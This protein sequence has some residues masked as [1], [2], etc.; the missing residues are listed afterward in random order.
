MPSSVR[1]IDPTA[2]DRRWSVPT[3]GAATLGARLERDR[4]EER[5]ARLD[6]VVTALR[7]RARAYDDAVVPAPLSHALTDFQ[8]E[9]DAVRSQL[10]ASRG[11]PE[12]RLVSTS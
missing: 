11:G 8:R 3:H 10:T 9:L 7:S 6:Q 2:R 1:P 5:A 12:G 4:L